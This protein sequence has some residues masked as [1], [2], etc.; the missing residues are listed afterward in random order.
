MT[1]VKKKETEGM[2]KKNKKVAICGTAPSVHKAPF[3]DDKFDIWGVAHCCFIPEVTRMDTIFELHTE[4]IWRKDNAP[5]GRFPNARIFLQKKADDIPGSEEFPMEAMRQ[6][7]KVNKGTKDER[8]YWSSS[9]PMMIAQAIDEGYE[10]I[11]IY[12]IHLLMNEEYFYQRPCT[13]Y[14]L[15]IAVGKGIKVYSPPDADILQF[16]YI[17]GYQEFDEASKKLH[18][19]IEEFESRLAG[20][21]QQRMALSNQLQAQMAQIDAHANQLIGA[22][23][24]CVYLLRENYGIEKEKSPYMKF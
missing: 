19:R 5:F 2:E 7:Y 21:Q 6:K 9:I 1:S 18:V 15:G 22:K 20:L 8:D 4:E 10:E 14:F 17:Y 23:E 16:G 11:H 24:D 13:E 3:K 12:G